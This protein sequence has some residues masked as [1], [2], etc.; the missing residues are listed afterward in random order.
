MQQTGAQAVMD[1]HNMRQL[2]D[3][4]ADGCHLCNLI[5]LEIPP[6]QQRMYLDELDREGEGEPQ[7]VAVVWYPGIPLEGRPATPHLSFE[8]ARPRPPVINRVVICELHCHPLEDE[9]QLSM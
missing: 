4:A 8:E 3:S 6:S 7:I 2:V 1:F 9:H 5:L